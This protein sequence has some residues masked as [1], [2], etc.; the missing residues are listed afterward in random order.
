MNGSGSTIAGNFLGL[1][2][3]GTA[4][5][6][7]A[8]GVY[9]NNTSGNIVGGNAPADRNVI[10]NNRDGI[11]IAAGAGNSTNNIVTGNYIGTNPSGTTAQGN[12]QRGVF[13]GSFGQ[14]AGDNSISNNLISGNGHFGI[15]LR[16]ASVTGTL[17]AANRIGVTANGT[18]ALP[19]GG[20]ESGD[21]GLA[22]TNAR[23]GVYIAASNNTVG[24]TA[25]GAGNTIAFNAGTGI[26]V[27]SGAD[28]TILGNSIFSNTG[29]D[30]DLGGDGVTF[31]HVGLVAGPNNYQN[32]PVL[33]LATSDGETTRV[34]GM[35]ESEANQNYT[36]EIFCERDL[37]SHVLRRRQNLPRLL[38][39]DNGCQWH[40]HF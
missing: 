23:A 34:G 8:S 30:I 17:I 1:R 37:Q 39:R 16:D 2:A 25:P 22:G 14:S 27:A 35:L 31:N 3:N 6:M 5:G 15:L 18:G 29:T 4:N 36:I 24:G 12:T 33:S 40:H 26:T 32:Y 20:S 10:S 7:I 13:V 38:L 9:L 28:N 19:N 21:D 11:F